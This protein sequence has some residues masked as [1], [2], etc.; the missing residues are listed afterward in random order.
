MAYFYSSR[1]RGLLLVFGLLAAP[2]ALAQTGSI[3]IGTAAPDPKA[4]LDISSADK[5]LLIPRLDSAQRAAIVA[6]PD[7]LMV[8]QKD[9]RVGLWY[10]YG[11]AW[12][13]IPDK[14][15]A[16][17]NLGNHTATQN[18]DLGTNEIRGNG[19]TVGVGV[20]P[21]GGLL[22]GQGGNL[23][24]GANAGS[25]LTSGQFN[26]LL[27]NMAGGT[28]ETGIRNLMIGNGAGGSIGGTASDNT[29]IGGAS[30]FFLT[31]IENVLLG[32]E[33]GQY[34][35]GSRNTLNGFR[36]GQNI[37]SGFDNTYVGHRSG[38]M[39]GSG[40]FNS[41]FGAQAGR[42]N[43]T[44]HRNNAFGFQ[45][46]LS[47][48][49][50]MR[51]NFMGM[52]AGFGTTTGSYNTFIGH[53]V[54]PTN[55]EGTRNTILGAFA[56]VGLSNLTNAT[57]IGY[58]AL[59]SQ[60]NSMA[61]GNAADSLAVQVGINTA[62]PQ[63]T[64]H[65]AGAASTVRVDGL[66]GTTTRMITADPNGNLIATALPAGADNLGNHTATQNLNLG[67]NALTGTGASISGTGIGV[68]ADGGLNMGQNT[69]AGRNIFIGF[70][71]GNATVPAPL[72]NTGNQNLFT[73]YQS[74]LN[75]TSGRAN[76]FS[77]Y[78]S[79]LGN[80]T[81]EANVF[82][83]H[84]SGSQNTTGSLNTAVGFNSGPEPF[85]GNLTNAT[86]LG[87]NARVG[88][89]NS[90]VL[91]GTGAQAVSVGIGTTAPTA[92]LHVAGAASTVRVEGMAG[93]GQ[94][95]V[96]ADANGNLSTTL[97]APTTVGDNLGNHTATTTLAMG[98]NQILNTGSVGI[99]TATPTQRLTVVGNSAVNTNDGITLRNAGAGNPHLRW[100]D[101][102][103]A[104]G[105]TMI[106][107]WNASSRAGLALWDGQTNVLNMRGGNI[108]VGTE[109]P[110]TRLHVATSTP[111]DG[112]LLSAN[113]NPVSVEVSNTAGSLNLAMANS[114]TEYSNAASAG[115]AVV[116]ANTASLLLTA[117]NGA[118]SVRFATGAA[119]TEKMRLT[120]GGNLGV[121][122]TA[123]A[124]AL[125][126]GTN[127]LVRSAMV[128]LAAGNG[129]AFRTWDVGVPINTANPNDIT[130]ENYDFAVRDVTGGDTRLL[131]EYATGRV[132]VGTSAPA[133][134]L[135]VVGNSA[136]NTNDGITLSNAGAGNP[137]LRWEDGT[138][139]SGL[140]MLKPWN[141]AGRGSLAMWDG[142]TNV[143]N[144]RDARIG[145]GTETP[146]RRLHV[147]GDGA[148][149]TNANQPTSLEIDNTVGSLNL[150][151]AATA[152][153]Y[154]DVA[155]P[156]DAVLRANGT[157]A[158]L[159]LAART[160]GALRFTTGA[161]DAERMRVANNGNVGVGTT[162]PTALLDVNGS[163]R[164]RGLTTAGVVT[165]DA[166]GNLS[167]A[168]AAT[169]GDNLGNHTATQ[170][171]ALANN[172]LR[173]R[174]GTDAGH[175]LRYQSSF[176]GVQ[177][178]GWEGGELGYA[179]GGAT[180]VVR[181]TSAGRVGIG[182]TTP[183]AALD[184][185]GAAR[186]RA[187]TTAGV[188]TN[189]ANGNLISVA[190][191]TLADNLGN[192][193]ATQALDMAGFTIHSANQVAIGIATPTQALDVNGGILARSNN[194]VSEQGAYLQWNRSG[195][196]GETWL[197]NQKGAGT[198]AGIRFG[199]VS[200]T[201]VVTEWA[202][203]LDNGRLGIGTTTPAYLLDANGDINSSTMVRTN[204]VQMLY[205]RGSNVYL[206]TG[207]FAVTAP[208]GTNNT[209]VG[210]NGGANLTAGINNTTVGSQ[211]GE[212]LT[213][214]AHNVLMG[215]RAGST[216]T[217]G[218]TNV[219]IGYDAGIANVGGSSN[220][221]VGAEALLTAT[222]SN[223]T[224]VGPSTGTRVTTSIRNTFVGAGADLASS[225]NQRTRATAIGYNALVDQDDAVVL[226]AAA[227]ATR[228]GIGTATPA[229]RLTV[230]VSNDNQ[231]GLRVTNGTTAGNI[232]LQPLSGANSGFA[233]L[234]FNGYYDG[235]TETRFNAAK[236]R[237]RVFSR[238]N[239]PF[240]E[241]GVDAWDGTTLR[242][243]LM[244]LP[245]GDVGI[246]T[247]T[248]TAR[249]DVNGTA[250]VRALTTA[251][252]VT[253]DANGN[254]ISVAPSTLGDNL[255]NHT[256]TQNLNL[257]P[258]AL[259]GTG[260]SIAGLGI[261]VRAD[262]GLNMGQND[263]N[264][265]LIGYQAGVSNAPDVLTGNGT[266]NL[267]LG[268]QSG[269]SN[270]TGRNNLFVGFRSGAYN[271]TGANNVALGYEAG[272]APGS[273]SLTNTAAIGYNARVSQSNSLVLGGTGADAVS[274]GI[275]TTAPQKRLHV[276]ANNDF[277]RVDNL[278]NVS[279]TNNYLVIDNA[280][281]VGKTTVENVAGQIIRLGFNA[282]S[283]FENNSNPA[284]AE[285]PLR[286]NS[287]AST[288]D[289]GTAP[290]GAANF[291]NTIAGSTVSTGQSVAAGNGT[292]ARTTDQITLP[293]GVYRVTVR[294][295]GAYG[296]GGASGA[297]R[298]VFVKFIVGNN[299]Y[300][301]V[302]T[303]NATAD[304][305]N[306]HNEVSDYI[307][308]TTSQ[309][310]DFSV[311]ALRNFATVARVSPGTGQSY[312]SLLLIERVR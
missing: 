263:G 209:F 144:M 186:V 273:P 280:G 133:Q 187:L 214:G 293:A 18:L 70:E 78:Q 155:A 40:F 22:I 172:E 65:V 278:A 262:G 32:A 283:Y 30:G 12:V 276:E 4:A 115:D 272:P 258:H 113:A 197:L 53:A 121:G 136:V 173:L 69:T 297:T 76:V 199:S 116:R 104:G 236:T 19:S 9:G 85:A 232:T 119:D 304:N 45:S 221:A 24:I 57:A 251:G 106:K 206:G 181:W 295:A 250:R 275:G 208:T 299:E 294:L 215:I 227:A 5:G 183:T 185:N 95:L 31:S 261:G 200:T 202:R 284:N 55:I 67:A 105:L 305:V 28:L 303:L 189:D 158:N 201:N 246:G 195:G 286:F 34:I 223:N 132:G 145:I 247:T 49:G 8:F 120:N 11:G 127:S 248:P 73:G 134:R 15:R 243:V 50:G 231:E 310:L 129:T 128:R 72:T 309:T 79:G 274:V 46:G 291:I 88:Q 33:S 64:L 142:V 233:A 270:T 41:F 97:G 163:A 245:T 123:P 20:T 184:V 48:S 256:A 193:T 289:M 252:V 131:V 21:Q 10:A 39:S 6:P 118:G 103:F 68:R 226:G 96:V 37:S 3:G 254:L 285:A 306:V 7:G 141:A 161:S 13:F 87:A 52:Q 192:H 302:E 287:H 89:S 125:Q 222:G 259:R 296:V 90:L 212:S 188:V 60:S 190:P 101:G 179:T 237:W 29:V 176:D 14:V 312:R 217:T 44:G 27:G 99:G 160:T 253:N 164:V 42:Q 26:V 290:N 140:T 98:G 148:L 16:G 135:H 279:N 83:G 56:N 265:I 218:S 298:S 271:T 139:V 54:A 267:F 75:N 194:P 146:T 109:S 255:G 61:L 211:A 219:F 170:N 102:A 110:T 100:E 242:S 224:A 151:M 126:L 93:S 114:A 80:T 269:E 168:T 17:D 23:L 124:Q 62:A 198:N 220:V 143:L 66:A 182:T 230:A 166:N 84:S 169:L 59:V 216:T 111:A 112:I 238:Q 281:N 2:A 25:G 157:G 150:G 36:A 38:Q 204:G 71:A 228:V 239:G 77:G 51:N 277:L 94:R 268:Y 81:G 43:G 147:A 282:A 264:N 300:S 292:L 178:Y 35:T 165:T 225:A 117:R 159:I 153:Q 156:G 167:S 210:G 63:A 58:K 311:R 244:A 137:H 288:T 301:L 260:S 1:L 257:G 74:G 180:P 249:L 162:A 171:L 154:S 203:F 307:N 177:L 207:Q 122:T 175:F 82:S 308:L 86:A 266:E 149:L 229:A 138:F 92:T 152:T 205:R 240:D 234:N 91:G 107:S 235:T 130:G 47:L 213:T 191:S 196:S 174:L 241:F 108:G